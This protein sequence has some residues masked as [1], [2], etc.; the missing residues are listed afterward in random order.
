[1]YKLT[2]KFIDKL[3]IYFSLSQDSSSE[4]ITL[5]EDVYDEQKMNKIGIRWMIVNRLMNKVVSN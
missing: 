4:H 2:Y 3:Y 1:M 5:I